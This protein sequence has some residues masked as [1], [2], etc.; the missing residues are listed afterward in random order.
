MKGDETMK[1]AKPE[2]TATGS[3]LALVQSQTALSK[4]PGFVDRADLQIDGPT[5]TVADPAAYEADE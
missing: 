1:Y 3:A 2:L 4:G 5:N